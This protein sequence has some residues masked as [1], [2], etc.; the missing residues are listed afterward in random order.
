MKNL[1]LIAGLFAFVFIGCKKKENNDGDKQTL[2]VGKWNMKKIDYLYLKNGVKED[3]DSDIFAQGSY[4]EFKTDQTFIAHA[5]D[6]EED[7]FDDSEGN[8]VVTKNELTL[9]SP[10]NNISQTLKIK[11]LDGKNLILEDVEEYTE[12][13][14]KYKDINTLYLTR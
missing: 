4:I 6:L 14:D 13:G 11:Q 2:I 8:Y 9:I 3:E 5:K 1:F 7:E 10:S 12:S